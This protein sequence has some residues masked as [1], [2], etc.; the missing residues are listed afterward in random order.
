M[1]K[2]EIE[3]YVLRW[4]DKFQRW[5]EGQNAEQCTQYVKGTQ[6]KTTRTHEIWKAQEEDSKLTA[7]TIPAG[8]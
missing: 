2:N 5:G 3:P 4:R 6:S 7:V 8:I 1:V